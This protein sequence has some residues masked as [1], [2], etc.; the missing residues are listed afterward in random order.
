MTMIK[1]SGEKVSKRKFSDKTQK[2]QKL[3]RE[4]AEQRHI[5]EIL[6]TF[7]GA[8]DSNVSGCD[9]DSKTE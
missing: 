2:A 7:W 4:Q 1:K 9:P 8:S 6:K 5:V 3:N